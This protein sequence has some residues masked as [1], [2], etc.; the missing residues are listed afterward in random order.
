M[1]VY[2][3]NL[4]CFYTIETFD[5]YLIVYLFPFDNAKVHRFYET[6]S[7]MVSFFRKKCHSFDVNQVCCVRTHK[8]SAIRQ[9]MLFILFSR[10]CSN[11]HL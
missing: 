9:N 11:K 10:Q 1:N 5:M 8:N 2:P 4:Y 6:C 7:R 3:N